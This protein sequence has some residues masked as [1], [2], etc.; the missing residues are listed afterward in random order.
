MTNERL[1]CAGTTSILLRSKKHG[2][3]T[4]SMVGQKISGN[5]DILGFAYDSD[6]IVNGVGTTSPDP[7]RPPGPTITG[8]IDARDPGSSPNVLDSYVVEEGA[9]P[10]ALATTLH[11]V[12]EMASKKRCLGMKR[13]DWFRVLLSSVKRAVIG[14]NAMDGALNRTQAF[15]VMAHDNNEGIVTIENDESHLNFVG[16]GKTRQAQRLRVILDMAS[17][18]IGATFVDTPFYAGKC[19]ITCCANTKYPRAKA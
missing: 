14:G 10:A 19:F 18:A 8:I 17:Q 5:G 15:L 7:A 4:S 1:R 16:V 2:L 11:M 9:I 3:Q 6:R 12:L 13:L